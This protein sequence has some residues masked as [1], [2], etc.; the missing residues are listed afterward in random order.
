[1]SEIVSFPGS[2]PLPENTLQLVER[3]GVYCDHTLIAL[4]DHERIVRCTACGKCFDPFT[5]LREQARHIQTAWQH[6]RQVQH[7]VK[8]KHSALQ[9]L[10]AEEKRLRAQVKRLKEKTDSI[11]L[12]AEPSK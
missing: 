9:T 6:H 4:D 2:E 11:D 3:K 5:F 12:R 8:E 1:M 7:M 10:Q